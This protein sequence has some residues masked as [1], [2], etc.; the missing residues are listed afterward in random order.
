MTLLETYVA[1]KDSFYKRAMLSSGLSILL[2][3]GSRL[4]TWEVKSPVAWLL[5]TV[6]AGFLPIFGPIVVFGLFCS[7]VL[8]LRELLDLRRCLVAQ[9]PPG[10][11]SQTSLVLLRA[12]L[13]LE[14][15]P[16]SLHLRIAQVVMALWVF[17]VPLVSYA[18]LLDTYFDFVR[19]KS[20]HTLEWK[21]AH[22]G[23]QVTDLLIGT[24]GWGGFRPLA[25]AIQSNLDKRAS[26]ADKSEERERLRRLAK[27]MPWIYPP[28]QTWAYIGVF[29][30]LSYLAFRSWRDLRHPPQAS[31]DT[32]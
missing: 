14:P 1:K 4:P 13:G 17:I 21:Y 32:S 26:D 24:G 12:P 20:P 9:L 6:N 3:A 22:R 8:A 2:A 29:V 30:L 31:G 28:I 19:P 11:E 27:S 10:P 23:A 16:G 18:I 7:A 15:D 5:G 25:P